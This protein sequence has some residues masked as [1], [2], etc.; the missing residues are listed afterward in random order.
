MKT[1][2]GSKTITP[3]EFETQQNKL[4]RM[5][6]EVVHRY[7]REVSAEVS[8]PHRLA[9]VYGASFSC[10]GARRQAETVALM[11]TSMLKVPH[12]EVTLVWPDRQEAVAAVNDYAITRP[13]DDLPYE[14]S[15]CKNVIATGREFSVENAIDHPLVC[16]TKLAT[17]GAIC[18][19]LGVPVANKDGVI[20]GV[21]C[22]YD[23]I[24]RDWRGGDVSLLTQ[25]SFVLTR[26]MDSNN[27]LNAS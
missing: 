6:A 25:L 27:V 21:L 12:C 1:W 23:T 14:E 13:G 22:V 3:T 9:A 7:H 8:D 19:Y 15:Y 20:V 18:S 2:F 4:R 17:T 26:A 10:A 24:E 16:D 11:A 5:S